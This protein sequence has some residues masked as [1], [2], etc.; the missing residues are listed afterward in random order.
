MQEP[1]ALTAHDVQP[2]FAGVL[3]TLQHAAP[4]HAV[5]HWFAMDGL[6]ALPAAKRAVHTPPEI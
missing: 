1:P 5:W 6:H 4:L 2:E 3:G